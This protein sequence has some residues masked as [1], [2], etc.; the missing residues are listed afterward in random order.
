[1]KKYILILAIGLYTFSSAFAQGSSAEAKKL[2]D[3]VSEK[4]R[5]YK[6]LKVA[7]TYTLKNDKVSPPLNEM[8]KGNVTLKGEQYRLSFMG[9]E[10]ICDGKHLW[11]ILLED[12]EVQYTDI[13]PE[14]EEEGITPTKMLTFYQEGYNYKMAGTETIKGRKIQY[15]E[16]RPREETD[17]EYLMLGIDKDKKRVYSLKQ[18][19]RNGTVTSFTLTDFQ[20]NTALPPNAFRYDEKKYPGFELFDLN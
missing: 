18:Y 13:D 7:F 5:S 4:T 14:E 20:T 11:N 15:V 1:M 16:L 17:Y 9:I 2:L 8:E 6:N 10:Q 19:G 3:A 12:K